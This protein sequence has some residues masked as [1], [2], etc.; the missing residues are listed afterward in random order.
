M[1][2]TKTK[3]R[4]ILHFS[5]IIRMPLMVCF[6]TCILLY[7]LS[8][9]IERS[10]EKYSV[11]QNIAEIHSVMESI[12]REFSYYDPQD[13]RENLIQNILLILASHNQ[14]LVCIVDENNNILYK[15]RGPNLLLTRKAFKLDSIINKEKT[16]IWDNDHHSYRIAASQ[17]LTLKKEK[18]TTI[19]AIERDFQLEFITRLHDGL[20]I[21]I[22]IACL[23]T[24][25]GTLLTIYIT[26]KP[27][28]RL[29]KIIESLNSK[30][31][32]YR[33]PVSMVSPKYI[34]L[35][36]AFNNMLSRMEF[37]FQRQSNFTADIAHEMRTPI[38]NL[39]TQT[40]IA[41]NNARTTNEYKEVLYS[42]LE[43]FERLSQ[44]ITDMLFLAHADNKL[45]KP[46]LGDIDLVKMFN[47]MFDYLEFIAEEKHIKLVLKGHCNLMQGDKLM[48][49]RAIGNLLSNAIHHTPN[50][51]TISV[52][53][54]QVNQKT[55]KI[56]IANPGKEIHKKHLP[57]LFDRFYR[58]DESRHSNGQG[59]G[60]GLA[61]VKSIVEAHNG[62]ISVESDKT[63]TRFIIMFPVSQTKISKFY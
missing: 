11:A 27:I 20:L 28:N 23:L 63:S 48:I 52:T 25:L 6:F 59:A 43:E 57:H 4:K 47:N 35:I 16:S 60:I 49:N 39:T 21:L 58:I 41:L 5:T 30:S 32:N 14:L 17:F 53:L 3:Y 50:G 2:L 38:T 22:C 31:L 46:D 56:V 29:I 9:F 51:E 37:V 61:I 24:L 44:I 33:I 8:L 12:E 34:S 18:Y 1:S 45:L 62:T 54:N 7:G 19:I 10:F 42:H 15:T 26:Q 40:Q 36:K 55:I 13:D